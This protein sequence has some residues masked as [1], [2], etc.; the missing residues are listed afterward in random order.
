MVVVGVRG[1]KC[2]RRTN[3]YAQKSWD[4]SQTDAKL[5]KTDA[6]PPVGKVRKGRNAEP[7][8]ARSCHSAAAPPRVH[9]DVVTARMP[10]NQ[11]ANAVASISTA[12]P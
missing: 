1:P 8:D 3:L 11:P 12:T 10:P 5:W 7:D 2:I 4:I 9:L 6:P